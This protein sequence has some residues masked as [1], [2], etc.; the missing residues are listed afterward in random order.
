MGTTVRQMVLEAAR[1]LEAAGKAPWS[2]ADIRRELRASGIDFNESSVNT[3]IVSAMC[4][5][6]PQN[7][8]VA[9]QDLHRVGRGQYRLARP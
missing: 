2:P 4:I 3:H 7:H 8:A 9:Y 5:E 6:A 1:H